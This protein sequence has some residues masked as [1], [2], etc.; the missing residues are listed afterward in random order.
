MTRMAV[1]RSGRIRVKYWRRQTGPRLPC[2]AQ[3]CVKG[4]TLTCNA[5]H[6]STGHFNIP[7]C[8]PNVS[9]FHET[10]SG[11]VRCRDCSLR[12]GFLGPAFLKD[13]GVPGPEIRRIYARVEDRCIFNSELIPDLL[14]RWKGAL[15]MYYRLNSLVWS[16]N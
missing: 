2:I 11:R 15:R 5:K 12:P 16:P 10:A 13:Y 9:P 3:Y 4:L 14:R 1:N 8:R 7:Y 6:A